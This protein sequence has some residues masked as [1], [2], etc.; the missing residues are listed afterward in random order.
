LIEVS[1]EDGHGRPIVSAFA[2]IV[3]APSATVH[4]ESSAE[5]VWPTPDP[6]M[7]DF[8]PPPPAVTGV[9]VLNFVRSGLLAPVQHELGVEY[10][11]ADMGAACLA[12]PASRWLAD[13][14]ERLAAGAIVS[15][16]AW[17]LGM[18]TAPLI[19]EDARIAVIQ[20]H[21]QLLRP[22]VAD[23]GR[24][25]CQARVTHDVGE[26]RVTTAEVSDEAGNTVATSGFTSISRQQPR[27]SA[28]KSERILATIL[29]S[30]IVGSTERAQHLGDAD[31]QKVLAQHHAIVRRQINVLRGREVKTTGDGFVVIFDAPARAVQCAIAMRRALRDADIRV[32]I[33]V[34]TG[35]CDLADGDVSGIAVHA[36]A[37][38]EAKAGS[39]EIV[40]SQTVRDLTAG[41]GIVYDDAGTHE[42]KG[43]PA[44]WQLFSV[45]V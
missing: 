18:A 17:T 23:G 4:D 30:D 8:E 14:R 11:D 42:L 19:P 34:H 38:I 12:M 39:D 7:R 44:T 2:S 21:V 10:V 35:E 45:H 3:P 1:V 43:L 9:A 33:G 36:A 32:R 22:V 24:L 41:S 29:F 25:T 28:P 20:H 40:V 13:R 27:D 15:L 5:P 31:W 37:R 6:W 26:F 16:T